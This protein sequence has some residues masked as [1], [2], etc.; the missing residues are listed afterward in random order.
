MA[1][2][3]QSA[4]TGGEGITLA[5]RLVSVPEFATFAEV[6]TE[7]VR[8]RIKEGYIPKAE[9]GRVLLVEAIRGLIRFEEE[10]AQR[11]TERAADPSRD[12]YLKARADE[13]E[14][15]NTR[16]M[17][18][19]IERAEAADALAQLVRLAEPA[20]RRR[21]DAMPPAVRGVALASI[22]EVV[23]RM[24]RRVDDLSGALASGDFDAVEVAR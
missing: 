7:W 14:G 24:R 16:A 21:V 15:R 22:E 10:K 23:D 8:L 18:D 5:A 19:L 9:R 2:R 13:I 20:L 11:A 3:D 1:K 12:R 17:R 6:S 4:G